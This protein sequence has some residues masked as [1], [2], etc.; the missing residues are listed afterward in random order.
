MTA[1]RK[2]IEENVCPEYYPHPLSAFIYSAKK[3]TH[4]GL[5]KKYVYFKS[6]FYNNNLLYC[7]KITQMNVI[8]DTEQRFE[9]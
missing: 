4:N 9:K 5:K 7:A 3:E 2:Q 6:S 8:Q 1:I